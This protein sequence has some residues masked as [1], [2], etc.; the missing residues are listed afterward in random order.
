MDVVLREPAGDEMS[1]YGVGFD[2]GGVLFTVVAENSTAAK[3]GFRTGDLL[4]GVNGTKIKTIQQLK[5]YILANA[6]G[7]KKHVFAVVRNQIQVKVP[8]SQPLDMVK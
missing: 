2:D 3:S 1:A 8:V 6:S 7:S 5:E 4:Q